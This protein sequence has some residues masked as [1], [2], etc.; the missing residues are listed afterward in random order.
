MASSD[1]MLKKGDIQNQLVCLFVVDYLI[2]RE[3]TET[4][5]FFLFSDISKLTKVSK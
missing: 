4:I 5:I 3:N 1:A 2:T